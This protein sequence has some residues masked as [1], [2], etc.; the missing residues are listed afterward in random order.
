VGRNTTVLYYHN[1]TVDV[2]PFLDSFGTADSIPIVT[3]AIAYDDEVTAKTY[4]FILHQA[5]Y[6]GDRLEHNLVNPFQCCLNGVH[7][8]DCPRILDPTVNDDSHTI[9]FPNESLKIPL[10]LN[11][12]VS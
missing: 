3:A 4:I 9:S 2:S 12:I 11:G 7:V 6:F 10:S 1:R 8:N 5:L